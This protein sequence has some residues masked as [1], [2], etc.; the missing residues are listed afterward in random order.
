MRWK[1]TADRRQKLG[2]FGRWIE[3]E[4]TDLCS[5]GSAILSRDRVGATD[6]HI[7]LP[8]LMANPIDKGRGWTR[9]EATTTTKFK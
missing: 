5:R 9:L 3:A 1:W 8:P 2:R 6:L 7:G 4:H